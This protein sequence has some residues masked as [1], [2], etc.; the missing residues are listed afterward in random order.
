MI[1]LLNPYVIGGALIAL[2][3]TFAGGYIKGRYDGWELSEAG[4]AV[5]ALKQAA[6]ARR[7]EAKA[8]AA[9]ADAERRVIE[10]QNTIR[11]ETRTIV[12]RVRVHVTPETDR[13][14]PLPCGLIR[15]HDAA[16]TGTPVSET[17]IPGCQSDTAPAPIAASDFGTVIAQNYGQYRELAEQMRGVLA[18]WAETERILNASATP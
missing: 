14:Y 6:E 4:H 18:A 15:V 17:A 5:A 10:A 9:I 3:L 12:E 13:R 11:V 7:T 8:Q 2:G 1:S 16:A